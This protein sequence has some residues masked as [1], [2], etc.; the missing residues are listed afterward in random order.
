MQLHKHALDLFVSLIQL[1]STGTCFRSYTSM[2]YVCN[3]ESS[4]ILKLKGLQ[5]PGLGK[6]S[7]L[8]TTEMV[9]AS[10]TMLESGGC[11]S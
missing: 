10:E 7:A 5:H 9:L 2:I 1:D 4:I 6:S 8:V 11:K 3:N